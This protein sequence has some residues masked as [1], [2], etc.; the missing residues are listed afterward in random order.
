MVG[1]GTRKFLAS[2]EL[3]LI[4]RPSRENTAIWSQFGPKLQNLISHVSI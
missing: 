2:G 4:H 1:W 3:L